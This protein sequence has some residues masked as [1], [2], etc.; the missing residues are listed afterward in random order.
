MNLEL[1]VQVEWTIG[2]IAPAG[3]AFVFRST[4]IDEGMQYCRAMLPCAA[5]SDVLDDVHCAFVCLCLF[6]APSRPSNQQ[7]SQ[8]TS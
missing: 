1:A 4:G 7:T 5:F 3:I 6:E 8:P 2:L